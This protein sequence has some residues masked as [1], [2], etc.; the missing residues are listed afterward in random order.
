MFEQQ[1]FSA[2]AALEGARRV[3]FEAEFLRA[4]RSRVWR[5]FAGTAKSLAVERE[6]PVA[7]R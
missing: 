6:I 3:D 7:G 1:F 2:V 4:I 5:P